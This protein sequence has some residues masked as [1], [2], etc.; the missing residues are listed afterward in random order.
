LKT[1]RKNLTKDEETSAVLEVKNTNSSGTSKREGKAG[2]KE[3]L[4]LLRYE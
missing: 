2:A 4:Y 1:Q 3:P